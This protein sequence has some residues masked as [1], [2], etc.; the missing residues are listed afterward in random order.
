MPEAFMVLEGLA[1]KDLAKCLKR[2]SVAKSLFGVP[3]EH[4]EDLATSFS[5]AARCGWVLR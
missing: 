2:S 4:D 1:E 5:I 3:L